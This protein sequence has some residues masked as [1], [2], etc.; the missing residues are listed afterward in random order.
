MSFGFDGG[1]AGETFFDSYFT[2][3]AGHQGITFLASSGDH[4]SVIP[5]GGTTGS[6]AYP[7]E[8]PNVVAVGGTNLTVS[9][10]TYVSETAWSGSGGG[11]SNFQ[12]KPS[13]QSAVTQS[14]TYRT[15]P[16]VS[17]LGDP[18]TGVAVYDSYNNTSGGGWNNYVLG[19]TSLSAPLYAG[20][21]A[22]ANQ[23]RANI[24]LGALNGQ[25]QTLQRLYQLPTSTL[26]DITS[27]SNGYSAT[28][29]YD[30]VSGRGTPV[31]QSTLTSLAGGTYT[32]FVYLD[33]DGSSTYSASADAPLANMAVWNDA[34]GNATLDGNETIA[35]SNASGYYTL[36]VA[37]GTTLSIRAF[38][39]ANGYYRT[40]S[41]TAMTGT[42]A[43]GTFSVTNNIGYFPITY[44]LPSGQA[45]GIT[46]R[47]DSTGA[48]LQ[49]FVNTPTT[50]TPTYHVSKTLIS[51]QTLTVNGGDGDDTL[52]V[53]L[54]YGT[55]LTATSFVFNGNA[56]TTGDVV[57]VVATPTTGTSATYTAT[58]VAVAGK[59]FV[60]SGVES[61]QFTGKSGND[62]VTMS[63][64]TVATTPTF[65]GGGGTD[66]IVVTG[67][68]TVYQPTADLGAD[69]TAVNVTVNTQASVIFAASQRL[70]ALDLSG[71][72]VAQLAAG[73]RVL[74]TSALS[75]NTAQSSYL[76]LTDGA[77]I[78]DYTSTSPLS[79]IAALVTSGYAGGLW[80]GY[81]IRSS[82]AAATASRAVGF[83]EASAAFGISG[84]TTA[85]FFNQSVDSTTLVAR[86]TTSG[87]ADLN[88]TTNFND[89]LR[90]QAGFGGTGKTYTD[91]DFDF[92]GDV[93][94]NDFLALQASFGQTA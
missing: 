82:T 42:T 60:L 73:A 15:T 38:Q 56:Q 14:S 58:S 52:T 31:G 23:G 68:A 77:L 54:T 29:G 8:S 59:T 61:R 66:S 9:G 28:T 34:N 85:T 86:Y 63:G 92:D 37:A 45:N 76:D 5:S 4:G 88:G 64:V 53:D 33:R 51:S 50:G 46:L 65:A 27:G 79:T 49:V 43:Y 25:T 69:G 40:T 78:Y 18:T 93:D 67:S 55:P 74:R 11:I 24:G 71:Q 7:A 41:S 32:G 10:N 35:Y 83:G 13:Y 20:V 44:T 1:F 70:N 87:D 19:G 72:G 6:S 22:V 3:P 89:F 81:G 30:L 94:F 84:A 91:G 90:M 80:N 39:S 21:V 26:H 12:S 48:R 16:D 62:T 57:N 36:D 2:T 17:I 47:L 75:I